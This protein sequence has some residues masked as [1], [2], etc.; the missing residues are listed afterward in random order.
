[1]KKIVQ[2]ILHPLF[3]AIGPGPSKTGVIHFV[4]LQNKNAGWNIVPFGFWRSVFIF[5]R[6]ASPLTPLFAG[7]FLRGLFVWLAVY[8]FMQ[9]KR[10]Q[11][12]INS[13]ASGFFG[14]FNCEPAFVR[15]ASY[16]V[17]NAS[18]TFSVLRCDRDLEAVDSPC[19]HE[20]PFYYSS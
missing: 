16:R 6:P 18:G 3:S 7:D 2:Q 20:S 1:V 14:Q 15:G 5:V 13:Q 8:L 4:K 12:A 19:C 17:K 11:L 10:Y 9:S